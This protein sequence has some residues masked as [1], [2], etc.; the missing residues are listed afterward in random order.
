MSELPKRADILNVG[1]F[2]RYGLSVDAICHCG[3]RRNIHAGMLVQW[4][5]DNTCMDAVGRDRVSRKLRCTK[6][7]RRRPRIEI[8]RDNKPL[9]GARP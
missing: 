8:V 9:D 5:G 7:G 1:E 3:H 6:C 4:F 2:W